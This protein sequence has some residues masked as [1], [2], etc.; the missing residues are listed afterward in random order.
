MVFKKNV[1][2][3]ARKPKG[4]FGR[5]LINKMNRVHVKLAKWGL[6]H[7]NIKS[8]FII[9]DVGCGGG[10]NVHNLAKIATNGKIYGIDHSELSVKMAKKLNKRFIKEGRVEIKQAS[11]S[12]LPYEKNT[13]DVVTGFETYYFW[14]D[15]IND[16]RGI[17]N[18]LKPGGI[19]VLICEE[20][21]S[22]NEA[23]RQISEEHAKMFNI[24]IH[25]PEEFRDFF[26]KAGF[27]EIK[28]FEDQKYSWITVIG[29]K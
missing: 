24:Q 9:L 17:R 6:S 26:I 12:S 8:D 18:I 15:L 22:K 11:V 28:M 1:V 5:Y 19:L 23:L 10:I 4:L 27:S 7:V 3:Q 29:K 2:S 21:K 14:P 13:F 20:Y 25:T 16:L